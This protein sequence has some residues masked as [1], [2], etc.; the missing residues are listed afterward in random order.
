MVAYAPVCERLASVFSSKERAG[1]AAGTN[2]GT[3]A[4]LHE[5]V[6]VPQH[7]CAALPVGDDPSRP[8]VPSR[9]TA[10]ARPSKTPVAA[11]DPAA[12][13]ARASQISSHVPLSSMSQSSQMPAPPERH[14]PG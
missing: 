7:A 10:A 4:Y 13:L 3:E 11:T 1:T 2:T 6:P 14:R 12:K 5:P 9:Y 8:I